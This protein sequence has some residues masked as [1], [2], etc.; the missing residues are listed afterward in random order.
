MGSAPES[1]SGLLQG[2]S[3]PAPPGWFGDLKIWEQLKCV[4]T[5]GSGCVGYL[6]G[7]CGATLSCCC[8]QHRRWHRGGKQEGRVSVGKFPPL[9]LRQKALT[10]YYHRSP[11]RPSLDNR[12]PVALQTPPNCVPTYLNNELATGRSEFFF[13]IPMKRGEYQ[14]WCTHCALSSRPAIT[15]PPASFKGR[16]FAG[17]IVPI[18]DAV[19]VC[20]PP[21]PLKP[22]HVWPNGGQQSMQ[23][24]KGLTTDQDARITW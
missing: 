22:S 12:Q 8:A 3:N 24:R 16:L 19:H 10:S 15:L 23:H 14:T 5:S 2:S 6:V 7:W 18:P 11:S 13:L 9:F 4:P 21:P 20:P 1:A 17:E